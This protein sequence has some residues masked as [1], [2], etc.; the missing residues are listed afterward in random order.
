MTF[1]PALSWLSQVQQISNHL[2]RQLTAVVANIRKGLRR[3]DFRFS[4][5]QYRKY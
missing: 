3:T 4:L 2:Q 1:S 5:Q